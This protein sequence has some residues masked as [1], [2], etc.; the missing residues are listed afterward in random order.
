MQRRSFLQYG[1]GAAAVTLAPRWMMAEPMLAFAQDDPGAT[2]VKP[3]KLAENLY[4]LQGAGGNMALQIGPDGL[5]LIDASYAP[6]VPRI[7]EAI[8]ALAPTAVAAPSL[9][10]N[11]HW[12]GDHTGGNEGMH[13][14]GFSILAHRLTRDRLSHVQE[15]KLFHRTVQPSPAAAL[16]TAV[17]DSTMAIFRNGDTLNLEH[18]APAH[19]DTD[20]SIH[21]AEANVLHM[22]DVWFNGMY[23]FIDEG[24]GGN[25]DGMIAGAKRGVELADDKTK[26]I[27]GH[28]PL[29]TRDELAAT[30]EMLAAIREKV[31]ALKKQ[32]LSEQE[33]AAKKPTAE[34]DAKW[35]KGFMSPDAITGIVYRTV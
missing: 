25:I 8:A 30:H 35:G 22:G 11:T 29:G 2:Q 7:R 6:A 26:I 32:G 33:T 20:I 10:I 15:M 23:P 18:F 12:H 3:T 24:T 13:A 1:L 16:P 19:T 14:V 17:F 21:F 28:G 27:P 4:L 9:L 31:A 34:F 5:L